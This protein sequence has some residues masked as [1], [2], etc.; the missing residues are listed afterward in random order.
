MST[1][2]MLEAK[3]RNLISSLGLIE[4]RNAIWKESQV[5]HEALNGRDENL[6]ENQPSAKVLNNR[7][8]M[9]P[10][11]SRSLN[12]WVEADGRVYGKTTDSRD[13]K[14]SD[15]GVWRVSK[16]VR[17]QE[18]PLIV[19]EG[20]TVVRAWGVN[21]WQL[22]EESGKWEASLLRELTND[23]LRI[24]HSPFLIGEDLPT[25]GQRAYWP[26][27]VDVD[28]R[29]YR[30]GDL[31]KVWDIPTNGFH[32]AGDAHGYSLGTRPIN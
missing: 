32:L 6:L 28:G 25:L 22:D 16:A 1:P 23:E 26:V 2:E 4:A 8:Q 17:D 14:Q 15:S 27:A 24:L 31:I 21:Y 5:I 30:G 3:I 29:V 7:A 11:I 10:T 19:A 9:W 12:E 13:Q 18:L 20:G